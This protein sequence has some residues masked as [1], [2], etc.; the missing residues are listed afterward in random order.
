[1][2]NKGLNNHIKFRTKYWQEKHQ[3]NLATL[4]NA[5]V[6]GI[7]IAPRVPSSRN[8]PEQPSTEYH[9]PPHL[10]KPAIAH[11]TPSIHYKLQLKLHLRSLDDDHFNALRGGVRSVNVSRRTSR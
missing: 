3:N 5:T 1:M 11:E 9:S 6:T 7:K 10:L 8:N 4:E 2:N